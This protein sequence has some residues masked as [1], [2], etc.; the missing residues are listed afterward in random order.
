MEQPGILGYTHVFGDPSGEWDGPQEGSALQFYI[1]GLPAVLDR[2]LTWSANSMT[3]ELNLG[4]S[5][6]SIYSPLIR[7]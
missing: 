6:T 3:T 7:R 2:S 4:G 1:N 5:Q